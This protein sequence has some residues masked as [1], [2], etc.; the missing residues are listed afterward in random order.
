MRQGKKDATD[1]EL[2]RASEIAQ[3]QEFIKRY[4]DEFDHEVEERSAN[5]SG[6]QKQRLSIARGVVSQPP[7]LIL[8]DST[9]ALDAK[10]E[11]LVQEALEHDLKNTTTMIIAEKIM[12]VKNADKILVL[13]E[14]KL[15]AMGSHDELLK[16]SK[17]YREIYDSQKAKEKRGEL[18]E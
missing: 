5:F 7:I 8:D 16:T 2:E 6:G 18:N 14:G 9:S 15:V 17:V 11:K 4:P 3:A 10:S 13:D 1:Y 12:S